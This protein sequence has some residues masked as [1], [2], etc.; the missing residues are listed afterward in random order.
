MRHRAAC[1][2]ARSA[3]R[4]RRQ[5]PAGRAGRDR[6]LRP[7]RKRRVAWR[8]RAR[9]SCRRGSP[10]KRSLQCPHD[11]RSRS[12]S[13]R[14]VANRPR[15]CLGTRRR[16]PITMSVSGRTRFSLRS[17]ASTRGSAS[18]SSRPRRARSPWPTS[19]AAG[20]APPQAAH[21]GS[22]SCEKLRAG[23]GSCLA[24]GPTRR[25]TRCARQRHGRSVRQRS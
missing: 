9:A 14:R 5:P 23:S 12:A 24:A 2:L 19:I 18:H 7:A 22:A 6:S 16:R 13:R 21:A 20:I 11:A 25:R 17:S 3:A 1:P 4:D 15:E 10:R 8:R